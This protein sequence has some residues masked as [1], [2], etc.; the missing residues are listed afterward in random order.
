M[1]PILKNLMNRKTELGFALWFTSSHV[2]WFRMCQNDLDSVVL[3][4]CNGPFDVLRC[5]NVNLFSMYE[6]GR[7]NEQEGMFL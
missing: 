4:K 7:L 1:C 6:V 3:L 5:A 2:T